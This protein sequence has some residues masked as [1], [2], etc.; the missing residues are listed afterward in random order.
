MQY[1]QSTSSTELI[2][3][4]WST[5]EPEW[6]VAKYIWTKLVITYD[7]ESTEETEPICVSGRSGNDAV[8]GSLSNDNHTLTCDV[9]GNPIT[10]AGATTTM[11]VFEGLTDTS[12]TW[13]F[14]ISKNNCDGT[15]TN[16]N[17]T[18]TLTTMSS[19]NAYVEFTA[20]KSGFSSIIKRFTI[21]KSKAGAVGEDATA[22]WLIA[23]TTIIR[24]ILMIV[25]PLLLLHLLV[26]AR[27]EMKILLIIQVDL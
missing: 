7:D 9:L 14:A 10:L 27:Q 15:L 13:N 24:K 25:Y 1:Y 18:F 12:D 17:R 2:G 26:E 16:N 20:S 3:G 5:D 8:V 21:S 6:D 22:Y 19:D 23:D 4:N 11:S